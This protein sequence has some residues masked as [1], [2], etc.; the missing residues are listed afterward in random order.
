MMGAMHVL[1]ATAEL[2]PLVAVGGL[3]QASAGLVAELRR[4]GVDVDAG[5]ARLRRD[6]RSP[7][8]PSGRSRCRRGS[9]RRSV[10][11]GVH[12]DV[13]ADQ[14]RA[15]ARAR[16][17]PPL[18]AARAARAGRTTTAGSSRSPRASR[19]SPRPTGRTCCTSTTGTPGTRA[20]RA[21]RVDP[22]R[23]VAAQ[24]RVP[25]PDRRFVAE[26]ASGPGPR[27]TSGTAARIRCRGRSPSPTPSSRCRR[28]TRPRS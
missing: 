28:R 3:A 7:A 6:R 8:R 2:A 27:T 16:A 21:R 13:G 26:A 17:Q 4:Q 20:G 18:P 1:F 25:G 15:G 19:R 23:A 14:P 9:G 10:R 24:P 12:P 22:E 5:A 11:T